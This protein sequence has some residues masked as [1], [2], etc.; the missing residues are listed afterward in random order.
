MKSE[1]NHYGCFYHLCLYVDFMIS[2]SFKHHSRNFS[3]LLSKN[4]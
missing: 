1:T 2:V 4:I 3:V